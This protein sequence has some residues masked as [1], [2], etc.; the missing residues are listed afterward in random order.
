MM[1]LRFDNRTALITGAAG[2]IGKGIARGFAESGAGIFVTDLSQEAVDGVVRELLSAGARCR[3]LAADVTNALGVE[4]VVNAARRFGTTI[5]ILVNV[6]GV[7]G[8]GKI[9][10]LS[11]EEWDRIFDVNCKGTFLFARHAVPLMKAQK[12]GRI[13]NFSSKSGKTGSALM[14]HYSAAKAAVIG[15]TQALAYELANDGITV[16]CLCP[17]ITQETGVW[18]FVSSGYVQ[19]LKMSREEVVKQFTSK[20]PLKR[21]AKV[22]DVVAVTLFL[23]SQGASY[24]TGQAINVTGGREMH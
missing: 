13:I 23:A 19:N 14:S 21:L 12:Y 8:Q 1:D 5:D 24:M 18:N 11:E 20:V 4:A 16:N 22:E 17:G 2:S 7:V 3:G 15:F 10:D 6:A 9:E